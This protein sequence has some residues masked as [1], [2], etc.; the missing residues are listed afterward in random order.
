MCFSSR[1]TWAG[2][3]EAERLLDNPAAEVVVDETTLP[4]DQKL[5]VIDLFAGIGGLHGALKKAGVTKMY[6]VFV[7][8]D[9]ECR[10]LLRR[11][12]PG[13]ELHGDVCSFGVKEIQAAFDRCGSV[14][15]IIVG[16]GSPC[17]GLS[18][19]SSLR[20]R[21]DDPRSRL[22]HE[23]VRIFQ[24]V[25]AIAQDRGVWHV[26]FL[27]NV[28]GD[29]ADIQEMSWHLNM[30]PVMVE[31]GNISRVKRPRLYWMSVSPEGGPAA[32]WKVTD[33]FDHLSLETEL[34]PL[35]VFLQEDVYWEAGSK[36]PQLRLPTFTR[37]IPRTRPPP[38]PAGLR[39]T[40]PGVLR[41]G[42]LM[43]IGY[44]YP[45]YTYGRRY[46]V[47]TTDQGLRPLRA[48]EREVLMGYDK[49]HTLAMLKKS[50]ETLQEVRT[51]EDLRCAAIGNSFHV[52]TVAYLFDA[53][54]SN[55][56]L[57]QLK[58][59]DE[60]CRAHVNRQ[61]GAVAVKLEAEDED[62][63]PVGYLPEELQPV[64]LREQSDDEISRSGIRAMDALEE[65]VLYIPNIAQMKE[66]DMMLSTRIVAAFIRRQEFRGSDVRLDLGSL[67]RPDSFPRGGI[68]PKRWQWHVGQSYPFTTNEHI[69][70]LELRALVNALQWRLRSSKFGSCRALHLVDSQVA[71]AV[72]VKGRSS[73]RILNK[74]L[75]RYAAL[76]VAGGV[77]PILGWVESEDNPADAPSRAYAEKK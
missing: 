68:S 14:A 27:E 55:M 39:G 23:A 8:K 66:H 43:G 40:S 70:V 12:H 41:G 33:W 9:K 60:I 16:G 45:P 59:I 4:D 77:M 22:F 35:S 64:V 5:L 21:L 57:K 75:K 3:E 18:K 58:G 36:D 25:E 63:M 32:V 10:R 74:L 24:E 76:Q 37:A 71:L 69:N 1:L 50:P 6:S 7:E 53:V 61:R 42:R 49:G 11:R 62:E 30:R 48:E 2:R 52:N 72:A 73:S 15:G 17:Q 29:V 13:S 67:Y 34:E 19:L 20:E 38:D 54:L 51:S 47:E 46:M 56:Q 65:D 26:K 28:V 31:S 44:R